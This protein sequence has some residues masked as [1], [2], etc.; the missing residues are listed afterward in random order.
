MGILTS[1]EKFGI[2]ATNFFNHLSGYSEKPEW[3]RIS[4]APFEIRETFLS[5]IEKEI[6]YHKE[7]GN[8][9]I[10]AKMN[11]LTD[12]PIIIKLYEPP[13]QAFP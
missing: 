4:T 5:L 3:H 9:R 1:D 8:G 7:H 11:S 13:K 2:D 12:K 10:I 6:E